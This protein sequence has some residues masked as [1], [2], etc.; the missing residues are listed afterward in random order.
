[1]NYHL[2]NFKHYN[3]LNGICLKLCR[4]YRQGETFNNKTINKA[5]QTKQNE[6]SALLNFLT[7]IGNARGSGRESKSCFTCDT[8]N[9]LRVGQ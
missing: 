2:N 7:A 5:S 6:N 8:D 4:K 9:N 3:I 1:M